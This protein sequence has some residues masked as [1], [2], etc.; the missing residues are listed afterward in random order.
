MDL[1]NDSLTNERF[2]VIEGI[3][4]CTQTIPHHLNPSSDFRM[5]IESHLQITN[6][7]QYSLALHS[8]EVYAHD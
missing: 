8:I 2:G 6:D 1:P 4:I 3:E 5:S 7:T